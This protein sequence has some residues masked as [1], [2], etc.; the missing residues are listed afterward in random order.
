MKVEHSVIIAR[1]V[2][3][4]FSLVGNP[5]NDAKWGSLIV[6]SKQVSPGPLGVGSRFEQTA[7]FLGA[8]LTTVIEVTQYESGRTVCYAASQPIALHHCRTFEQ[9]GEGT[10]LTFVTEIEA[11]GKF[12]AAESLFRTG[13]RRQME[14]DMAE[15]KTLMETSQR[16]SS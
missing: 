8:R 13:A 9:I 3:E 11:A 7:T 14:T 12:R 1:S 16:A 5:D 15:I 6:E 2:E 10:R 4:V